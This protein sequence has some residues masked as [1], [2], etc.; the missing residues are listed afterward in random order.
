MEP[1]SKA[2][3]KQ[4]LRNSAQVVC[5]LGVI[6]GLLLLA[7]LML[8]SSGIFV[9]LHVLLLVLFV[10]LLLPIGLSLIIVIFGP[11]ATFR[12]DPSSP[13]SVGMSWGIPVALDSPAYRE[14]ESRHRRDS[15]QP[16]D[17]PP[18]VL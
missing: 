18:E 14:W 10:M 5:V 2:E 3:K 1:M 8:P 13:N 6:E 4:Q 17:E 16:K 9:V 15:D 11:S 7:L 12:K